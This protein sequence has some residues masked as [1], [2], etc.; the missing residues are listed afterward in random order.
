MSYQFQSSRASERN[1]SEE[2]LQ[3]LKKEHE[4][5]KLDYK[6]VHPCGTL[7][8]LEFKTKQRTIKIPRHNIPVH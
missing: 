6:I 2:R 5:M 3:I 1:I 7:L 8:K 4:L